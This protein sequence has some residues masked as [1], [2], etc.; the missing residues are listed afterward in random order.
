MDCRASIEAVALAAMLGAATLMPVHAF[1]ETKYP[2]WKGQWS[3][4]AF[5]GVTGQ[6]GYDPTK[7]QGL[8]Q[9]A[10]LTAKAQAILD[11]SIADQAKGGQGNDPT[12]NC[13]SPG[14]P[15]IMTVYDP[16]E[17]VITPMAVRM[18]I[19]HV[20]D[21]RRI[22]TDGRP[23]PEEAEPSYAGYSIGTWL[24]TDGDGRYDTLEVETR[25]FKGPRVF[26]AAGIPLDSDNQ[27]VVKERIYQDKSDP[28]L[29]YDELTTIDHALTRP[30]TVIKKMVRSSN[31]NPV[32]GEAVCAE[33]NN[34]VGIGNETYFMSGDGYLMPT[35]KGQAPPDLRYFKRQLN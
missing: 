20:H 34:H 10:P 28:N 15:R 17:I 32:W 19:G 13:L 24:D 35:R 5:A 31:P 2:D 7:G 12:Y 27:T 3:R 9:Q 26:D 21:S 18:L 25:G 8:A 33:G 29:L 1:D 6:P 22:Y 23:W 30:W 11:A 4:A 14:M 16:M